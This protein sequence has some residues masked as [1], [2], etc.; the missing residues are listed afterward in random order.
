L[1][2]VEHGWELIVGDNAGTEQPSI[3]QKIDARRRGHLPGID[4]AGV[5]VGGGLGTQSPACAGLRS[6]SA[7]LFTAVANQ[8]VSGQNDRF[9]QPFGSGDEG[10]RLRR[11]SVSNP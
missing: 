4:G 7:S 10:G 2:V 1:G 8:S 5:E 9:K 6:L 3:E 11:M